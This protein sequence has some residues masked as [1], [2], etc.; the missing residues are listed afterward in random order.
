MQLYVYGANGKW[1]QGRSPAGRVKETDNIE[2]ACFFTAANVDDAED[3]IELGYSLYVLDVGEPE[4]VRNGSTTPK[5]KPDGHFDYNSWAVHPMDL[6]GGSSEQ[7][8]GSR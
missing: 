2:D 8:E 7:M 5:E 1:Y 3:C 6:S 4:L